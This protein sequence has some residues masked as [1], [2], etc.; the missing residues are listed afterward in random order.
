MIHI[1]NLNHFSF[2]C[3]KEQTKKKLTKYSQ[4]LHSRHFLHL[5]NPLN[6]HHQGFQKVSAIR[7][8]HPNNILHVQFGLQGRE[9]ELRDRQSRQK[10][11]FLRCD[12]FLSGILLIIIS[13]GNFAFK[14]QNYPRWRFKWNQCSFYHEKNLVTSHPPKKFLLYMN[15]IMGQQVF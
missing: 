14:Y 4:I 5:R 7:Q 9:V 13:N 15:F 8:I 1:K 3:Y 6:P 12:L 10:G 2:K 11:W